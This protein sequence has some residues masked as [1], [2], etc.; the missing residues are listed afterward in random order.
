M[1]MNSYNDQQ[2]LNQIDLL[3]IFSTILGVMNYI[4]NQKQVTN[5]DLLQ[6]L[7]LQNREYFQLLINQNNKIIELLN[8]I[9]EAKN[10]S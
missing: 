4:E 6:E 7:K 10:E 3:T 9:K 5:D 8:S 2:E 1:I